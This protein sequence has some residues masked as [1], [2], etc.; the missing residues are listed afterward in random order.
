M[1]AAAV[2][3]T[4]A[5]ATR[6][7]EVADLFEYE[8]RNPVTVR[9]HQS[10]LVP[11]LQERLDG[12]RV[13]LYNPEVRE[14][15][16]MSAVELENS[17]GLTLEGGPVT[18]FEDGRY[19]GEAMLETTKAGEKRFLPFSVDLGV[20]VV[21]EADERQ[22]RV[23]RFLIVDGAVQWQQW[24]VRRSVYLLDNRGKRPA[25]MLLDHRP[26]WGHE[27][28]DT[29][30]PAE[31]TESFH[32]FRVE[33]PAGRTTRFVVS[34]RRLQEQR[35]EMHQVDAAR[36]ASFVDARWLDEA[37]AAAL[38]ALRGTLEQAWA[39]GREIQTLEAEVARTVKDQERL[40][41][42]LAALGSRPEEA[43]LRE[44]Y[45]GKLASDE[46]RLAQAQRHLDDLRARKAALEGEAAAAAQALRYDRAVS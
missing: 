4:A 19:V 40:R 2:A 34:E 23:H 12:R 28:V 17:T 33:L 15:N 39:L 11:I 37:T 25:V 1:K 42:N 13:V 44:R 16:P 30:E 6:T 31:R 32:R 46:D 27:L 29:P 3:R 43:A 20:V 45:V 14:R 21:R 22:D 8:V 10:A 5:V 24:T 36:I 9:R 41:Q 35:L 18:V 7:A 38:R 26:A